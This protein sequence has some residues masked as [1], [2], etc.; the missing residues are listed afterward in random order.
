MRKRNSLFLKFSLLLP[1]FFTPISCSSKPTLWGKDMGEVRRKLEAA[2]FSFLRQIDWTK[3]K[4]EDGRRLG[5]GAGFYLHFIFRQ[6]G[7]PEPADRVLQQEWERGRSIWKEEAGL[8]WLEQ[9][10][11]CSEYVRLEKEAR[12]F[13]ADLPASVSRPRAERFLLEA[14]YWQ[15]RDE[16]V[17]QRLAALP[18]FRLREDPELRLYQAVCSC[19][20]QIDGWEAM[21]EA[22]F[23]EERRG[24]IHQRALAFLEQGERISRFPPPMQAL[25]RAKVELYLGLPARA[26][27]R[28]EGQ[29]PLIPA[30]RLD[31]SPILEELGLA[32]FA[33]KQLERGAGF[34]AE[35][36]A[37]LPP[38]PQLQALEMAGRLYRRMGEAQR[39]EALLQLVIGRTEDPGQR[40]RVIWY[41]LD[42]RRKQGFAAL[43]P[44]IVRTAP[45]WHNPGYFTDILNDGIT[46]L[47]AA[48]DWPSLERLY[49]GVEAVAPAG[50][51][52]RLAYLLARANRYPD[53]HGRVPRTP[54]DLLRRARALQPDGYYGI[55]ASVLLGEP[56]PAWG[57]GGEPDPVLA[58]DPRGAAP[59][60]EAGNGA[61]PGVQDL[62]AAGF[63]AVADPRAAGR[64]PEEVAGNPERAQPGD[65][66]LEVWEGFFRFGLAL[67][68]YERLRTAAGDLPPSVLRAYARRLNERGL[69]LESIRLMY[70]V[71][72]QRRDPADLPMPPDPAG[73]EGSAFSAPAAILDPEELNLLYPR[74]Y[75]RE[76][77]S[78]AGEVG[79]D[80]SVLFA[81]VR[82]ESHF[83]AGIVSRAGAVGLTQLM[84]VTA[85]DI[86]RKLRIREVDL[87]DPQLNLQ[88]GSRHLDGLLSR[89]QDVPKALMA[90]NAG[91]SRLRG[92]EEELAGLPTDLFAEAVP[93]EETRH[94]LR[95]I[96]VSAV[97]Y[98]Y[99]YAR[100][101][102][103]ETV[104][105]FYPDFNRAP[106][107]A[108]R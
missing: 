4:P 45:L 11:A 34:L 27:D 28:L 24:K 90:Y 101:S 99:L 79:L 44:E 31:A 106:G 107:E 14:L 80:A 82:E 53:P 102:P 75:G 21:F 64:I 17:L 67:E 47:T 39:A 54:R 3:Q 91:L 62:P 60:N 76:I 52:A 81:L 15:D 85:R 25:F 37:R 30:E 70:R 26:I 98:G 87:H 7:L 13:L 83:D 2:D 9:L 97:Y 61:A 68:G 63:A 6:Q 66:R 36:S 103:A 104:R 23:L 18:R 48:R 20:R 65:P 12:R 46:E 92:W 57:G 94:Y 42:L 33:A 96:L 8:A 84:P 74:A 40:D 19:R 88:L 55:L 100:T 59:G 77:E 43:L 78:R 41:H 105:R 86:A 49:R 22:L 32:Y 93:Y 50:L 108:S 29:L 10:S 71:Q 95:K 5:D 51:Q 69:F 1:L 56:L 89:L 58:D 35:L 72:E 73:G 16:D 38:W